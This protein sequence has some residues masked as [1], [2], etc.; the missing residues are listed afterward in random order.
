MDFDFTKNQVAAE[1]LPPMDQC[2]LAMLKETTETVLTEVESF[3]LHAVRP[4]NFV[5]ILIH[6]QATQ[7]LLNFCQFVGSFYLERAKMCLYFET[8]DSP[9]RRATQTTCYFL[10][11]DLVRLLSP[12]LSFMAE[13]V[14]QLQWKNTG[15]GPSTTSVHLQSVYDCVSLTEE[16]SWV[17][18]AERLDGFGSAAQV[19]TAWQNLLKA[20]QQVSVVMEENRGKAFRD[21]FQTQLQLVLCD[22]KEGKCEKLKQT[23]SCCRW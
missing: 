14:Y 3:N 5:F 2:V 10:L 1:M 17:N 20:K 11:S 7:E 4:G 18:V 22:S 19:K 6:E 21:S 13:E 8:P 12:V 23:H 16:F 15:N 9:Q